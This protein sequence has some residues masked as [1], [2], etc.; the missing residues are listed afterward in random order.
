MLYT[1]KFT[2]TDGDCYKPT[3]RITSEVKDY[4]GSL[5]LY[6]SSEKGNSQVPR[7]PMPNLKGKMQKTG[8]CGC[9]LI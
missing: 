3:K 9:R 8:V 7:N 4:E 2:T 6:F 5:S 1:K